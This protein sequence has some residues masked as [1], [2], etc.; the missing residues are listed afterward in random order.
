MTDIPRHRPNPA[1]YGD[2]AGKRVLVTG[3]TKGIGAAAARRFAEAGADV[4]VCARTPVD[5]LPAG[6][7]VQADVAKPEDVT[8]LAERT[9]ELLGGLDV[10]VNNAGGPTIVPGGA[11]ATT[12]D[13]WLHDLHTNLLSSVRLDRALLPSMLEQRSGV[14]IHVGS[15]QARYAPPQSLPYAAAKAGLATYSK[16]LAREVGPQGVRVNAVLPGYIDTPFMQGVLEGF[17]RA[18]GTGTEEARRGLIGTYDIPLGEL[19]QA[20]D[21]AWLL[22]FLASN[23]GAYLT[24]SQYVVDGGALPLV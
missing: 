1:N 14:V 9:L 7:F 16:G 4:V 6:R 2:L 22:L 3:G 23:A 21:V 15:V 20:D 18:S 8:R 13:V 11:L 19:G 12:D 24:G 5:E 17:A 10:L